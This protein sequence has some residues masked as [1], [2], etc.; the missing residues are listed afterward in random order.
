MEVHVC[1]G[2]FEHAVLVP[3]RLTDTEPITGFLQRRSIL[4][5]LGGIGHHEYDIDNRLGREAGNGC[6]ARVFYP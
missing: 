2:T 1:L 6:R 3:A 5:F 4:S